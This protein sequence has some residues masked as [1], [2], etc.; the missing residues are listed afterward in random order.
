MLLFDWNSISTEDFDFS[1]FGYSYTIVCVYNNNKNN[2]K[3]DLFVKKCSNSINI[4]SIVILGFCICY[5][6]L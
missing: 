4:S 3:V 5:Y 6:N 1:T 2:T